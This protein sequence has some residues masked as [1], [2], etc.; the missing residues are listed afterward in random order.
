MPNERLGDALLRNGLAPDQVAQALKVDRKTVERWVT[1]GRTPYKKYRHAIAAMVRET[2][3]YLWPDALAPERA[4]E[5]GESEVVRIYPH[6]HN[7]PRELW[8]RLLESAVRD[9]EVLVYSGLFLTDDHSLLKQLREKAESGVSIRLLFGDPASPELARR[10]ESE[11]IGKE[12][13]AAKAKSSLAFFS[14]LAD[15]PGVQIRSHGTTLY[16]SIYRFDDEMLVNT[17]VYGFM[18]GHAPVIHLRQ[19]SAGNMFQTYI[20]SFETVW[21]QAKKPKW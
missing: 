4:A 15:V 8:T 14:P 2:E 11:G 13:V 21:N 12:A 18:A 5:I 9:I 17:H 10:S 16:N 20:E 3:N 6:R 1:T 19:L 7:V